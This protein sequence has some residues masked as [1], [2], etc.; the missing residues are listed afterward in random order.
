M[1]LPKTWPKVVQ[2]GHSIAKIY[3]TP[4]NGCDQF[5]LVYYLGEKRIRKTFADYELAVTEAETITTKLSEGE[6]NVL[7]LKGEDQFAYVRTMQIIKPTGMPLEMLAIRAAELCEVITPDEWM[8]AGRFYRKHHPKHLPK[9]TVP[10]VVEELI[11][12][13]EAD[14][15][16]DYY[17]RDLRC[18]LGRFAEKFPGQINLLTTAEIEKY[19][20]ELAITE[21]VSGGGTRERIASPKTRN[22][23]RGAIGTLIYFAE[24]RGY[25]PKGV[26]DIEAVA[27]AKNRGG[28]IDIF[29][30]E[31]WARA[32]AFTA[33]HAKDL[34]PFLALGAFAGLRHAE[35]TR[36]DWS[37]IRLNEKFIEVKASKAKTAGRRLVPISHNLH[38]WL[39]D[40][41]RSS[42]PICPYLNV[43]NQLN[44]LA[45]KINR[46]W[47]KENP[48]G[49]FEWKHNALR[50]SFI[51][52]R[53]AEIQNVA[54]VALEAGNSPKIIF[55]NYR[56]LVRPADAQ[57]WFGIVP[58]GVIAEPKPK[59]AKRKT[60]AASN[61]V[62]MIAAA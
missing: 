14:R 18:R 4:S 13:K 15:L 51:S 48:A 10:E 31:E 25:M 11:Q 19:L 46:A 3:R 34:I 35:I 2:R 49:K 59:Q 16:S 5:T 1:K 27:V 9:K 57:K 30:P 6:L 17:L 44:R 24:A 23:F 42:G 55:S 47:Q 33:K 62:P 36:L 22:H 28:E 20:R 56:E 40:Y 50:H 52:Y 21:K 41:R 12:A 58:P 39:D 8:D 54:Q 37:E 38:Q 60:K 29:R 61:V 53:V 45:K 32:M 7:E 43:S 26:V